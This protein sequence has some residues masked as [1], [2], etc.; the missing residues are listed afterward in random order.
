[1][2]P[3]AASRND[4]SGTE[5]DS[6]GEGSDS[7]AGNSPAQ[8]QP[9]VLPKPVSLAARSGAEG[10]RNKSY[11]KSLKPSAEALQSLS[12]KDGVNEIVRTPGTH[13]PILSSVMAVHLVYPT[14][15]VHLLRHRC[16]G[17]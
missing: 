17:I 12:L 11:M 4:P 2:S 14:V 6:A 9:G 13:S 1:M 7:S 3:L 10:S 8:A 5:G 16:I 15:S